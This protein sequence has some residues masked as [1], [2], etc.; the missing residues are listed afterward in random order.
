VNSIG[1][2]WQRIELLPTE[3]Q[4]AIRSGLQ[5]YVDAL[6]DAYRNPDGVRAS[7]HES[8]GEE[9]ART[10]LWTRSVAAC[11]DPNGEKARMLLLPA[12]N[13]MFG[14]VESERIARRLHPPVVIFV[15]LGLTALAAGL[16]AGYG[17]SIAGSTRNWTYIVGVSAAIAV[18]AYV[19]IDLEFPRLGFV[20]V[21]AFDRAIVELRG[22]LK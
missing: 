14:L 22:T 13:E 19:I 5:S 8:A 21:D 12:L 9:R 15:M 6:I 7:L 4:G 2:A 11:V 16:F 1:T 18:A 17:M 10:D 3:R 20:R